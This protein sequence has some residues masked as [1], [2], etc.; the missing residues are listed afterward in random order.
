MCCNS[1]KAASD[2]TN[3][4][5]K[6]DKVLTQTATVPLNIPMNSIHTFN[7]KKSAYS[8]PESPIDYKKQFHA[9]KDGIR[10]AASEAAAL[11]HGGSLLP[12]PGD[13]GYSWPDKKE[14]NLSLL[15]SK[16]LLTLGSSMESDFQ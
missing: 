16:H 14:Q 1:K 7:V 12:V 5:R 15:P 2:D 8:T 10:P 4:S 11:G 9:R 3:M 13:R 6:E